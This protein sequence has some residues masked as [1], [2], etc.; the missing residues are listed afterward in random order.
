MCQFCSGSCHNV[1]M[2][3]PGCAS[4]FATDYWA[5]PS[6][7]LL[8]HGSMGAWS[9]AGLGRSPPFVPRAPNRAVSMHT[10][11]LM[12]LTK[13]RQYRSSVSG[14]ASALS[15]VGS[16]MTAVRP[17]VR[18]IAIASSLARTLSRTC[19]VRIMWPTLR[20]PMTGL[21]QATRGGCLGMRPMG[22]TGVTVTIAWSGV[23]IVGQPRLRA[24]LRTRSL[25][26]AIGRATRDAAGQPKEEWDTRLM[27]RVRFIS[28]SRRPPRAPGEAEGAP[29]RPL[30]RRCSA[31]PGG[32][33]WKL[34]PPGAR[35]LS[36]TRPCLLVCR[37]CA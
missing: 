5:E 3:S 30:P 21:R 23:G 9:R 27:W 7:S 13:I 10:T 34:M 26:V 28:A 6:L 2:C 36:H 14:S 22:L 17:D 1:Y 20:A 16:Q 33:P 8:M 29:R 11:A 25:L 35:I 32:L 24:L 19:R 18:P 12:S 31:C 4:P 15:K 37:R